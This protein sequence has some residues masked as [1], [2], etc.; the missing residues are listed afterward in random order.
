[1][2]VTYCDGIYLVFQDLYYTYFQFIFFK[3]SILIQN[4]N[5]TAYHCICA[6]SGS[7]KP[8]CVEA[9]LRISVLAAPVNRVCWL[10]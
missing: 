6:K 10:V 4:K 9:I 5:A 1:M 3:K 8:Q 7:N 2:V